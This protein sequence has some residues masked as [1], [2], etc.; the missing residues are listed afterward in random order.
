MKTKLIALLAGLM[1]FPMIVGCEGS[2]PEVTRLVER[3]NPVVD[4]DGNIT[5]DGKVYELFDGYRVCKG[6]KDHPFRVTKKDKIIETSDICNFCR[7]RWD[8]HDKR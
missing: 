3:T 4:K 6:T 5:F 7:E 2:K 1:F 8:N